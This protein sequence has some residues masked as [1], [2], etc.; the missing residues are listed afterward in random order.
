MVCNFTKP[1]EDRPS[2]LTHREVETFFH[3][4][5]HVMHQVNTKVMYHKFSGTSVERDFV[6]AP[7]QMLENWCWNKESLKIMSA[8]FEDS[9]PLPDQLIEDLIKSRNSANGIHNMRQIMFAKMDQLFHTSH[10][11][12]KGFKIRKNGIL[13][14]Y[15]C[16]L[17]E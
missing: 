1:T 5:G 13:V 8:H 11:V 7:S 2:L 3:E 14:F 6:E 15:L 4:F 9:T 16:F 12:M 17:N 10:E